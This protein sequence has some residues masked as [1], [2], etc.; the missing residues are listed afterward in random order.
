MGR[1]SNFAA[2]R[3]AHHLAVER[4]G[5][6]SESGEEESDENEEIKGRIHIVTGTEEVKGRW[7]PAEPLYQASAL[8]VGPDSTSLQ[9]EEMTSVDADENLSARQGV[10]H[11]VRGLRV[12]WEGTGQ[13]EPPAL[14]MVGGNPSILPNPRQPSTLTRR[15]SRKQLTHVER[16][17]R[18]DAFREKH[19][20][21]KATLWNKQTAAFAEFIHQK[22]LRTR[23]VLVPGKTRF[24]VYWDVIASLALAYT[25]I[26]TPFEA[27]FLKATFGPM[28]LKDPWFIANRV[29]DIIFCIDLILQFFIAY[30]ALNDRGEFDFVNGHPK[31]VQ[32]YLRSWFALDTFTI[33]VPASLDIYMTAIVP[34]VSAADETWNPETEDQE[35]TE[36]GTAGG[37]KVLSQLTLFRILRCIRLVKLVRLVRA[38]RVFA[39]WKARLS[40]TVA[41]VAMMQICFMLLGAFH[42]YACIMGLQ[43]SMQHSPQD[44]WIGQTMYGI[45]DDSSQP[46]SGSSG[47]RSGGS[48]AIS[49][50]GCGNLDVATFYWAAFSW[51]VLVITGTGGT[52]HYPSNLSIEETVLVTALVLFGALIWTQVL[53]T[54]CDVATNSHPGLT[55]YRHQLDNLTEF[56][57][58]NN[59]PV[60]MARRMREFLQHQKDHHL[61]EY[62]AKVLPHLSTALQIEVILHCHRHWLESIWFLKNVEKIC[63]VRIAMSM[64]SMVIAPGEVAPHRKLYVIIRG[65]VLFGGKI[66][67]PGTVWGDDVLL[68]DRR[69]FLPFLARAM[70]YTDVHNLSHEKL[71]QVLATFPESAEKI[72]RFTILLA[73]K[74]HMIADHRRRK[75]VRHFALHGTANDK[76]DFLDQMM[77]RVE[78]LAVRQLKLTEKEQLRRKNRLESILMAVSL[79]SRM[80]VKLPNTALRKAGSAAQGGTSDATTETQMQKDVRDLTADMKLVKDN[81]MLMKV[82]MEK[83]LA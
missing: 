46:G 44:T 14:G 2:A 45:C 20:A 52:D 83:L 8:P 80:A 81:M 59:L 69:Y 31:I 61:R 50:S 12:L 36:D 78:G 25:A 55:Q 51:S 40:F 10:G 39:R 82:M 75:G 76:G 7:E 70:S 74:R 67:S 34:I 29:L 33:I 60:E 37:T 54:F 26:L 27:S 16:Q 71:H 18:K 77:D 13:M 35:E 21:A 17:R 1:R 63:C 79:Q 11:R 43:A 5:D 30:E 47:A 32:R 22:Q 73:L 19:G 28:A 15:L 56:V 53:A 58:F 24:L 65:C 23:Y 57:A 42:W 48:S 38:S 3:N 49:V 6:G 72:R 41:Q 66:L 62:A 64:S 9:L 4:M 68:T